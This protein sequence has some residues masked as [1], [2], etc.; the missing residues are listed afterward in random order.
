MIALN[1][2]EMKPFT[3]KLF[4]GEVFD[5]FLIKEASIT[6]FNTFTIDGAIRSGY[7]TEDE[8]EALNLGE[9]STWAMMK[10]F[11]FSLIKGKRLPKSFKIVMQLP[12]EDTERFLSERQIS[13]HTS[14]VKGLYMNIRYEDDRLTCV[15]GSSVSVFTMDKTLD[16]EWDQEVKAFLKQNQIVYLEE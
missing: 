1:I 13:L 11:C 9:L 4:V 16:Q 2:E 15:T 5:R 12:K 8:K 10:P 14:E 3:S 7:Y 6:T